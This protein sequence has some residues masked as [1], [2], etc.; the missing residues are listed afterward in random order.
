MCSVFSL[1]ATC[2]FR[3]FLEVHSLE[4]LVLLSPKSVPNIFRE[5]IYDNITDITQAS[6]CLCEARNIYPIFRT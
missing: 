5:S 1:L 2:C 3:V 6:K 4:M